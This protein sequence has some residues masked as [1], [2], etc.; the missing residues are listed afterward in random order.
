[1]IMSDP[2]S[3]YTSEVFSHLVRWFGM[4]HLFSLVDR[5]ESN[6]VEGSNKQILR[7]LRVLVEDERVKNEWSSP[8]VLPI[9]EYL[10]NSHENSETGVVPMS[11]TFGSKDAIY[12]Q[13]PEA[14]DSK[15]KTHAYVTL[16]DDNLKM[17]HKISKRFQDQLIVERTQ[18]TPLVGSRRVT[19]FSIASTRVSR[20]QV[21]CHRS[22]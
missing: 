18:S 17:L 14:S 4:N 9:V 1:M 2:G 20:G 11:A 7:H 8:T 19:L 10:V 21:S 5:H 12:C 6:G 16:L 3:D 22:S 15:I 13:L